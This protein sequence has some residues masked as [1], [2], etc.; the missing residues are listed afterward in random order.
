MTTGLNTKTIDVIA[1]LVSIN[2]KLD[3]AAIDR[4]ATNDKL[5]SI[6]TLLGGAPPT[7]T[8]TLDDLLEVL[9]AIHTDTMSMDGK[10]LSIRNYMVNPS[11]EPLEDDYTSL[12]YNVMW[13]RRAVAASTFAGSLDYR[14]QTELHDFKTLHDSLMSSQTGMIVTILDTLVNALTN[15]GVNSGASP[16]Y[17]YE[18]YLFQVLNWLGRLSG[19]S[20]VPFEAG[21]RDIIQLL[22][23]IADRPESQI[24]SGLVPPTVCGDAYISSGM[25]LVPGL[26]DPIWPSLVYAVFPDP[27]PTGITFGSVFGIGVDNTELINSAGD[28]DGYYIYVASSAPNYGLYIGP[29][30]TALT[31]YATN[32]WLNLEG[33][34]EHLSVYVGGSDSLRVYL[35]SGGWAPGEGTSSGGPWG[36]DLPGGGGSGFDCDIVLEDDY[37]MDNSIAFSTEFDTDGYDYF[38]ITA[39]DNIGN[40][41]FYYRFH[42]SGGYSGWSVSLYGDRTETAAIPEGT[43]FLH[44][45]YSA[46]DPS[47]AHLKIELCHGAP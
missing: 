43:L 14:I 13:L 36:G 21:N 35:C 47:S 26:A 1:E 9:E 2:T 40:A 19:A 3:T 34:E 5:D 25:T 23:Q 41:N 42:H 15:I 20:G 22:A 11:E 46:A 4:A 12:I 28:W 27:P 29:G 45:Q 6:I 39:T 30:S 24:G 37:T 10:L 18:G 32:V 8:A 17:T 7:P 31:R 44:V 16:D 38:K 33:Y